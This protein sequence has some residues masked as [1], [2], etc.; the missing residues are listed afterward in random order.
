MLGRRKEPR[1]HL[2][3]PLDFKNRIMGIS[4]ENNIWLQLFS[5]AIAIVG[6]FYT[7][8]I[9][10]T[11]VRRLIKGSLIYLV[12]PVFY[13]GHPF[14]FYQVWMFVAASVIHLNIK[15][16]FIMFSI[17]LVIVGLSQIGITNKKNEI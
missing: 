2:I 17:W 14:L 15:W 8:K 1:R 7:A 10:N 16:L 9:D 3:Q 4:F 12:F 5:I 11:R 6:W 13:F